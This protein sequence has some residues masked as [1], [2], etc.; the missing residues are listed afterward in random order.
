MS[1]LTFFSS[2]DNRFDY[3]IH[4]AAKV[5]GLFMNLD[6]NAEMFSENIKIN[7]NILFVCKKYGIK[8][9]IFCLSSCIYPCNPSRFPMDES[10]IHESPPHHSNEGYAYAK[11]MLE[12][13]C[14]Q[15]NKA[16]GTEYIC[17]IP[18]NLYGPHDNFSIKNGHVIPAI[19]NRFHGEKAKKDGKFTPYGTGQAYRQFLFAKDFAKIICDVL[20]DKKYNNTEPLI[21][22]NDE[23][24]IKE[25][26]GSLADAMDISRDKLEWDI[27]KSDG[28]MK[29]T[30]DNS[31]LCKYYP[32]FKFTS[33]QD[34]LKE[35]YKWFCDNQNTLR[36]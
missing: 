25:M 36:Q 19:M 32:D 12:L 14:R 3:I 27:N 16:Y 2:G 11:R 18:V 9:G 33:L 29:K 23:T 4:L 1:V 28:C 17:V 15:Y 5:G 20:L 21:C 22:C 7:E 24:T 10:M 31:K 8:R 6:S 35:T 30:V 13:Q 34:G 26:V